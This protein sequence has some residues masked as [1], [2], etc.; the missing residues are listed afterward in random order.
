MASRKV[1]KIDGPLH[2]I[3][4]RFVSQRTIEKG[5]KVTRHENIRGCYFPDEN[6]IF[7]NKDMSEEEQLHIIFHELAH[8]IEFQVAGLEEE[9]RVDVIAKFLIQIGKFKSLKDV[10]WLT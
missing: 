4:V 7:V 10:P 3:R 9:S 8:A 1:R 6:L 2:P 5:V